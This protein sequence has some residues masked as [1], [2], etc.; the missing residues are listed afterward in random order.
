MSYGE[1]F[2]YSGELRVCTFCL[3]LPK[4]NETSEDQVD[5]PTSPRLS[6][7]QKPSSLSS[8]A[9]TTA[10]IGFDGF[11]KVL[12]LKLDFQCS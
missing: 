12:I 7:Q 11:K 5:D 8:F 6:R 1:R 2:G 9:S 10:T 3:N 4:T